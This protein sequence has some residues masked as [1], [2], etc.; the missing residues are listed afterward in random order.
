MLTS[1]F[2]KVCLKQYIPDHKDLFYTGIFHEVN[3]DH[4][5]SVVFYM[6]TLTSLQVS[7]TFIIDVVYS[8]SN[9]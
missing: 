2:I 1:K 4:A 5:S 8:I 3:L 7:Y 6:V 9:W